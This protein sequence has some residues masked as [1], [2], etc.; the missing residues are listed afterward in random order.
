[1]L[2]STLADGPVSRNAE[3]PV[4]EAGVR[5][6][7]TEAK[8]WCHVGLVVVAVADKEA[9]VVPHHAVYARIVRERGRV[10]HANREGRWQ[11][12]RRVHIAKQYIGQGVAALHPREPP[13]SS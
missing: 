8:A 10:L 5:Q 13:R 9:L 12:S 1:M 7:V 6:P 4:F 2:I 11:S 3:L